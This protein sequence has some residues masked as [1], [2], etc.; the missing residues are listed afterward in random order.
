MMSTGFK[1]VLAAIGLLLAALGVAWYK[2]PIL[3]AKMFEGTI[4]SW[5]VL[6]TPSEGNHSGNKMILLVQTDD[7]RRVSVSSDRRTTAKVSERIPFQ[8]RTWWFG[9]RDY[10]EIPPE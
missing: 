2:M 4:V 3:D 6:K 5:E 8:E 9:V 7:G 10:V 1:F